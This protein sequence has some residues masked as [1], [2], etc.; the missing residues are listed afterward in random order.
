MM[1]TV[2]RSVTAGRA[3]RIRSLGRRPTPWA[4]LLGAV[5]VALAL[6]ALALVTA[7]D[8]WGLPAA[9][10]VPVDAAVGVAY[11]G[12]AALVLAG[13]GGHR[14]GWLLLGIGLAGGGA[15]LTG[16]LLIR[17]EE[18]SAWTSLTAFVHSWLWVPGFVPLLTLVPLLYPHG[19]LPGRRWRPAAAAA[20]VGMG[21]LAAG[22]ALYPE[23]YDGRVAVAKPVTAEAPAQWLMAAAAVVLVPAVLAAI[24]ALVVRARSSEGLVRRQVVVLLVAAAV[25]VVD[26]IAQA[27]LRWPAGA[28]S[29]AAAVA[30]VPAAIAVA[31]TRH[32]LYDLD[33]ALLRTISVVSLAVS[34]AGVYLTAFALTDALLPFSPAV[35]ATLSAAATGVLVHPLGVR[36]H[37]GVERLYYG[38]RAEPAEVLARFS[39]GLRESLELTEVPGFVCRSVVSS[40]RMRSASLALVS[41]EA[42][43]ARPAPPVAQAG[44]T[45]GPVEGLELRHR[46]EVVAL[47]EVGPRPGETRLDE[48]DRELLEMVGDQVAPTLAALRLAD[49][50]QQSRAAIVSAREEERRRLR[51][52]LHD[53]VGATLAGLRLQVESAR[54]LVVDPAACRLLD[55][56]TS[57]VAAAVDDLR[58]ITEDLRPPVLDDLGLAAGLRVLAER[59]DTPGLAVSTDLRL[60]ENLPAAVD[61]ACFRIASEALAN[62]ARHSGAAAVR[63]RAVVHAGEL[64]LDVTDDG[65]GITGARRTGGLGLGSMRQRAEEIGGR[66]DIV[67]TPAG[68]T[69]T[70]RLPLEASR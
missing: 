39:S 33:V 52:D 51:R 58:G 70:A 66:L 69:V 37:R 13:S 28:L 18:T 60:P 4:G 30:L 16:A 27:A 53:G 49:S 35:G 34:L 7:A 15:A 10:Q 6:S 11:A 46:G 57:A 56:A 14:L 22:S 29:Q 2:A 20:L 59:V 42:D 67:D 41:G 8:G 48:R 19:R 50:L 12:A 61:V 38:D 40:L 25:L 44:D 9:H 55:G 5:A 32:R 62:A 1:S 64:V 3:T 47:L 45:D 24:A 63:V 23:T 17:A 65:S 26:T 43:A 54:E 68:L 31:V 21:L 36:L